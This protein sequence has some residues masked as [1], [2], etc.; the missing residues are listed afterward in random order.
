ME[1]FIW[2]YYL[3]TECTIIWALVAT[4]LECTYLSALY[5]LFIWALC[6][7][8]SDLHVTLLVLPATNMSLFIWAMHYLHGHANTIYF[9]A[10]NI[11]PDLLLLSKS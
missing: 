6:N 10:L 2:T 11:G 7:T 3:S 5:S 8:I 4:Y 9:S 1:I